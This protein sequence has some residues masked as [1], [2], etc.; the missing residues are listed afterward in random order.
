MVSGGATPTLLNNTF[1]NVQSP[2]IQER[3]IFLG[4]EFRPPEI[5]PF[6]PSLPSARPSAVIVGGNTYQ[7]TEAAT[8]ITS[9]G[10]F[11]EANPTNVP[12]T[13]S[14][15]NFTAGNGERL[16]VDFPGSIFLPNPQ[17]QIIDSSIDSLPE[18]EGFRA[19]KQ[20]V[21][22]AP[23]PILAPD[24]DFYGLFR[25]DDPS[26]APPSG[27]GG[28]VFKDRGAIDRA[29][30]FGPSAIAVIKSFL[31]AREDIDNN[32]FL[33][34][35]RTVTKL[36]AVGPLRPSSDNGTRARET[37]FEQPDIDH[38]LQSFAA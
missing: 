3:P 1:V 23:S 22:I 6:E 33:S 21:G 38:G 26:V 14:D 24:R 25:A 10:Q 29:D 19:I 35:Q 16:F 8:P 7:Y 17:S 20:A 5:P 34:S 13:G 28:S 18:R 27:L 36:M 9:L 12:N 2:I 32:G 11:V 31:I 37:S 30:F 15:F 4:S